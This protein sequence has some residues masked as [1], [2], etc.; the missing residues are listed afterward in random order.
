MRWLRIVSLAFVLF[1]LPILIILPFG[2]ALVDMARNLGSSSTAGAF[3]TVIL[4]LA[5][6]SVALIPHGLIGALAGASLSWPAAALATWMG[7]M[8]AS[9]IA[10]ALGRFAG[11]P[12]ARRLIG[13]SDLAAAQKRAQ[14]ISALVL[15][16]TRPVPVIGEVIL[17]AAGIARY[18]LRKFLLAIGSANTVLALA[19]TGLGGAIGE[20]NP[21]E[22]LMI[23]TIGIPVTG[24]ALYLGFRLL[25]RL[26]SGRQT[27]ERN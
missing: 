26:G 21:D 24:L 23:A 18:S 10:Y 1:A 17:I 7:I 11:G 13:E 5:L 2:G 27:N 19:Y 3:V 8:A 12:L 14:G 6:D 22:L 4:L 25:R 9:L 16:A 20:S 15:F